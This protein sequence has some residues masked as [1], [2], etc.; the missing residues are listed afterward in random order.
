[1][2]EDTFGLHLTK[3][4]RGKNGRREGNCKGKVRANRTNQGKLLRFGFFLLRGRA[5]S[6]NFE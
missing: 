5:N 2:L 6:R 3:I 1:M 4:R